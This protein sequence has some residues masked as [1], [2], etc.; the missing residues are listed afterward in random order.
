M[1]SVSM[2][3]D[4]DYLALAR[5][6]AM[7]VGALLSLSL[8]QVKDL[9]LAVNE[10]CA[11]FLESPSPSLRRVSDEH[12][13]PQVLELSYD[14]FPDALHVTVRAPVD[15]GWPLVDELGWAMLGAL[16]GEVRVEVRGGLGTLI[17]IQ[18]LP[19]ERAG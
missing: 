3:A 11:C 7:H 16:V 5:T 12:V 10:A 17:L 4:A 14:R 13:V 6:S 18:P 2:L 1:V 9:R 15:E 19:D 8:A